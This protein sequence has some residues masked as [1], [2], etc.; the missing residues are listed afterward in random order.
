MLIRDLYDCEVQ[1]N[2]KINKI[3]E[4]DVIEVW[5]GEY[6][7]GFDSK[8]ELVLDMEIIYMYAD[9]NVLVIEYRE[10]Y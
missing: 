8:L 1:G 6:G 7:L 3:T 2:I 4:D 9:N 10:E 5:S